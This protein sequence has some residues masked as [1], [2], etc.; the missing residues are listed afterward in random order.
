MNLGE[1]LEKSY[2]SF[3]G[4]KILITGSSGYIGRQISEKLSL[5][6][7]I[8]KGVDKLPDNLLINEYGFNLIDD[9]KT[10]ILL[11]DFKPDYIFHTGTNSA[12]HYQKDFISA[13]DEDFKSIKNIISNIDK[14]KT[15]IIFYSSS[16]VYSGIREKVEEAALTNPNHNFGVGKRFFEQILL[17]SV[18]NPI[19]FRL[20]SVFGAGTPRSPN[21]IKQIKDE[22]DNTGAIN[23]W[24]DGARRMQYIAI[25][26]VLGAS[27][28]GPKLFNGV[29]NLG[30]DDYISM[31][32]LAEIIKAVTSCNIEFD[33][34]RTPGETLPFMV[35]KKIANEANLSFSSVK[36]FLES[37]ISNIEK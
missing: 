26:D 14:E 37:Y 15:K 18:P 33:L 21:A 17:R 23:I 34:S 8:V 3:K 4:K 2:Q 19:I 29:Y 20:S 5:L 12:L 10:K 24:G 31:K 11:K 35:N 28:I 32:E 7:C 25:E 30:S 22:V 6:G 1:Q 27:L 9:E 16:Y 13:Y 36:Q